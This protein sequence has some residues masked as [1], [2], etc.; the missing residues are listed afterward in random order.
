MRPF[1][2][3]LLMARNINI[4]N[5][6]V[7]FSGSAT[8][9]AVPIKDSSKGT[10]YTMRL[11]GTTGN[12]M[13]VRGAFPGDSWSDAQTICTLTVGDPDPVNNPQSTTRQFAYPILMIEGTGTIKIARGE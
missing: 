8:G 10:V 11:Y 7:V 12:Q 4:G 6:A 2:L 1:L 3:G 13:E 9:S 5:V